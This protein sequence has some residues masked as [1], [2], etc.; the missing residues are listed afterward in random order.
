MDDL[1]RLAPFALTAALVVFMV[2]LAH[3]EMR[4]Q[5]QKV[6]QCRAALPDDALSCDDPPSDTATLGPGRSAPGEAPGEWKITSG[7]RKVLDSVFADVDSMPEPQVQRAKSGPGRQDDRRSWSCRVL[8]DSFEY[9]E[10][11]PP[12]R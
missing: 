5:P 3:R 7:L 2:L 9:V 11:A 1:G 8:P 4:R 10:Q 6:S 12:S